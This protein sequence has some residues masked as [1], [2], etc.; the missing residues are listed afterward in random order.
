MENLEDA[1]ISFQKQMAAITV[2]CYD[3]F[4]FDFF[5]NPVDLLQ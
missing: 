3:N 1:I 2:I 5:E 4:T